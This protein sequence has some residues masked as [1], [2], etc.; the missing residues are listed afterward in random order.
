ML[1]TNIV[2]V[3]SFLAMIGIGIYLVASSGRQGPD[4][5]DANAPSADDEAP[6][7]QVRISDSDSDHR[8]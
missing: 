4:M 6:A 8:S 3:L 5:R 7:Q 1:M 2:L